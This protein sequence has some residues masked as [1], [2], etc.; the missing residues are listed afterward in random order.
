[1]RAYII[2]SIV[3][4]CGVFLAWYCL[5]VFTYRDSP[6]DAASPAANVAILSA[7]QCRVAVETLFS[8][9]DKLLQAGGPEVPTELRRNIE[10]CISS[11]SVTRDKITASQLIRLFP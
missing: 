1:M 11:D 3:I 6:Q 9:T 5:T 2:G 7:S 10:S 8:M 4:W